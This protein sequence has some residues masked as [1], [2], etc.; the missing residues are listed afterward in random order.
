VNNYDILVQRSRAELEAVHTEVGELSAFQVQVKRDIQ[1]S[2][3]VVAD[4]W[5]STMRALLPSV[6]A[7]ALQTLS[8][9]LGIGA[10]HPSRV[11]QRLEQLQQEAK[12]TLARVD[13]DPRYLARDQVIAEA[14]IKREE[15]VDTIKDVEL[16]LEYLSNDQVFR[17]LLNDKYDTDEYAIKWWQLQFYDDWREG[18]LAVER[19][20]KGKAQRFDDLRTRYQADQG[21]LQPLRQALKDMD[22]GVAAVKDLDE[23][24]ARAVACVQDPMAALLHDC[25]QQLRAHIEGVGPDEAARLLGPVQ[26]KVMGH[27][28]AVMAKQRYLQNMDTELLA[29]QLGSARELEDRLRRG[30][31]KLKRPKARAQYWSDDEVVRRF[32]KDRV[33]KLRG[34]RLK[35]E[36]SRTQVVEYRD[37]H[38]YDPI[39]DF[40]WWD[41]MTDGQLDGNFTDD[42]RHRHHHHDHQDFGHN[43]DQSLHVDAS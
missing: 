40:L 23:Q 9:S 19:L 39:G 4:S 11:A 41:V 36:S 5:T 3:M 13:S 30:L 29:P 1:A 6:D 28:S 22:D 32:S 14:A 27:L 26:G 8:S 25:H 38:R 35:W 37:Y 2:A 17:R 42:V 34:N 21:A 15:L 24:R 33:S 20:G 12:A 7:A 43:A 31:D 18:D 10:L 16:G